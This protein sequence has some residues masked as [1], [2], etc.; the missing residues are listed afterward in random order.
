MR[1]F[2]RRAFLRGGAVAG[3]VGAAGCLRTISP[4]DES[5]GSSTDGVSLAVQHAWGPDSQREVRWADDRLTVRCGDE[6]PDPDA[7][8]SEAAVGADVTVGTTQRIDTSSLRRILYTSRHRSTPGDGVD[9]S[10]ADEDVSYAALS[11]TLTE[12][13]EK[14]VRY[15]DDPDEP[16]NPDILA[17]TY[18]KDREDTDRTEREI[19]VSDLSDPAFLGVG[20]NVGSSVPQVVTLEVFDVRGV[21]E[22][23]DTAFRLDAASEALSFE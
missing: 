8:G 2:S 20:A 16:D 19:D 14:R 12:L 1:R 11:R 13:S 21:D 15:D 4:N 7:A 9:R 6:D 3:V 5:A 23:G 22:S 17:S 18:R 10:A